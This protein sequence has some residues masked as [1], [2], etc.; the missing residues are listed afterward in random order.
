MGIWKKY[1][2]AIIFLNSGFFAVP[3]INHYLKTL[4][5]SMNIKLGIGTSILIWI[6]ISIVTVLIKNNIIQTRQNA[7]IEVTGI[8]LKNKDGTF[9]TA[10]WGTKKEIEEYL[11]I[12]KRDGI[13]LRRN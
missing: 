4:K 11:G 13:I 8:N 12:N 5:N 10:D 7:K 2:K 3:L 1:K 9:G 6:I